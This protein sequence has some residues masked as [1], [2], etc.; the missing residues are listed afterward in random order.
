MET[1]TPKDR[2]AAM[3]EYVRAA[4]AKHPLMAR[5]EIL[6]FTLSA[7]EGILES[8]YADEAAASRRANELE[9][10]KAEN[11]ALA[12]E[13]SLER[14]LRDMYQRGERNAEAR[15]DRLRKLLSDASEFAAV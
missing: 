10:V 3:A 4:M 12:A 5:G 15:A 14:S 9:L 11:A 6:E 8:A 1:I 13:L 2:A 7:M